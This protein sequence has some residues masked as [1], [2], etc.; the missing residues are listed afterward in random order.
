MKE[1]QR[2]TITLPKEVYEKIKEQ[3]E[4]DTR[5][6]GEQITYLL[7]LHVPSYTPT[8]SQSDQ[9]Y[10]RPPFNPYAGTLSKKIIG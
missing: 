4:R 5:T 9:P 1:T 3:A 2:I 7:K 6:I 8:P 10:P